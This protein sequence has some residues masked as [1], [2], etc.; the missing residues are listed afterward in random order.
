MRGLNLLRI[1]DP[2]TNGS[3]V[4][5]TEVRLPQPRKQQEF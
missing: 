1:F 4:K 5:L 3:R 2:A